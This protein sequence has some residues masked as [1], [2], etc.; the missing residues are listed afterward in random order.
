MVSVLC[1]SHP[2]TTAGSALGFRLLVSPPYCSRLEYS[3]PYLLSFVGCNFCFH[4]T[5]YVLSVISPK[6]DF[7]I[8]A[9][10]LTEG[11][12][13]MTGNILGDLIIQRIVSKPAKIS[14]SY[15]H[16]KTGEVYIQILLFFPGHIR[17]PQNI[18][19]L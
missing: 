4:S 18:C 9:Y 12:G 11:K 17:I 16:R 7:S 2:H 19:K 10:F 3:L 1:L 13:K 14:G 5:F 8:A 6:T 15:F